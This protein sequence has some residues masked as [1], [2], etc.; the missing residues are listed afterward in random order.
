[1]TDTRK[2]TG[3]SFR[4]TGG[5]T[6]ASISAILLLSALGVSLTMPTTYAEAKMDTDRIQIYSDNPR[7]WQYKGKSVLL[8][9][10]S[11]EDNLFQ[12]PDLKEH[13]DLLQS[14]GATMS[15]AL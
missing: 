5:R 10:G 15:A 6:Y 8:L 13:L 11:V 9:G 4:Q 3:S 7:Y 1:M 2:R 14:V 12:I